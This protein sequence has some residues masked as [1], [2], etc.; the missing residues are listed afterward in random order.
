[1]PSVFC[2]GSGDI[3]FSLFLVKG[4][5]LSLQGSVD[6]SITLDLS[7]EAHSE[8]FFIC[9]SRFT[10]EELVRSVECAAKMSQSIAF[11]PRQ[12]F[13]H[14]PSVVEAAENHHSII[15]IPGNKLKA[16]EF[17]YYLSK[18]LP[19]V[20][21][22]LN[23]KLQLAWSPSE[24]IEA[25]GTENCTMEDCEGVAA[26]KREVPLQEFLRYFTIQSDHGS[27]SNNGP[28]WKVKVRQLGTSYQRCS[29]AIQGL[30]PY[31]EARRGLS[32]PLS[33]FCG[34]FTCT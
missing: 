1:M 24:L 28:I 16:T 11:L 7:L 20:I 19:L 34:C 4:T 21:T 2:P 5:D 12:S 29:D 10:K 33:G 15:R 31:S 17:R 26:K 25:Y 22:A 8:D 9:C 27:C 6:E 18:R 23:S 3:I 14:K 13:F 30:A 32:S